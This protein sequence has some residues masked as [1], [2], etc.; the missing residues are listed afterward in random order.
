MRFLIRAVT[1]LFLASVTLGLLALAGAT[2]W[3]AVETRMAGGGPPGAARERV[4]AANVVTVTPERITPVLTAFGEVES[5]RRLE[6]RAPA[7]GR[8]VELAPG[9]ED[10]ASVAEGEL[11]L[12]IDPAPAETALALARTGLREAEN[13]WVEAQRALALARDDLGAAEKQAELREEAL[14]RQRDL[15]GRS[16]GTAADREAAELAASTA[17][18]A[19]LSRRQALMEAEARVTQSETA[20][21]RQKITLAEAERDL[22]ETELRAGFAGALA[23]VTA[24]EGGLVSQNEKIGELIDPTAL[25]VSFRVSTAEFARLIDDKGQ[26]RPVPVTVSL[27]VFGA[28]ILAGGH[29]TR[30]SAAVGEGLT[31]RLVYAALDA[32]PGFRPGDFVSVRMEEPALENAALLPATAVGPAGTVLALGPEDRLEEVPVEVLRRQ[33]DDVII[34]ARAIAGREVV[35]ERSPLLGAGIK[36]RPLRR[37]AAAADPAEEPPEFIELAPERRAELIAFVEGNKFMPEEAKARVLAQ[38][39]EDKVPVRVVERLEERMGG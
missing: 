37:D 26:L 2:L 17:T 32:A 20:L 10:G 1:G 16:L 29:L 21:A 36:V 22:A 5:R 12:R 14:A 28:E 18:Q 38:L 31:G 34:D 33:G 30:V 6:L 39:R 19:V 23:S 11:L 9:F 24:V 25:D 8:I 15:A 27:D 7:A 35:A 13:E 4:F 3:Q